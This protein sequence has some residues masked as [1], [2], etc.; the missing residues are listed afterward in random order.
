MIRACV[1]GW[2]VEHSRGPEIHNKG[3]S[4][5]E[6]DGVYLPLPI[7]GG[8]TEYEHFKATVGAMIDHGRLD[9]RG[10]SVTIPHKENLV[11]FVK[12]RG[13]K[14]IGVGP[15]FPGSDQRMI[16]LEGGRHRED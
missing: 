9:F 1:I 13:G 5:I 6:F 2:P 10:A 15:Q 8:P 4:A 7:P 12:E 14:L 16:T 3:F 11:R